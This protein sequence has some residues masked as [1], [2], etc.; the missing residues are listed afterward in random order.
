MRDSTIIQTTSE[1]KEQRR[2]HKLD[3]DMISDT[4]EK[5]FLAGATCEALAKKYKRCPRRIAKLLKSKG[6][7]F[8]KIKFNESFLE[9]DDSF[10][11]WFGGLFAADGNIASDDERKVSISQSHSRGETIISYIKEHLNI[12]VEQKS[13]VVHRFSCFS[14]TLSS[15]LKRK[16]NITPRKSC[17]YVPP[18]I[19]SDDNLRDFMRGYI[20]G[21]GC[22]G[23]YKNK[24]GSEYILCSMVGTAECIG[25]FNDRLKIK[26]CISVINKNSNTVVLSFSGERAVLLLD[27]LYKNENLLKTEKCMTFLNYKGLENPPSWS[28]YNKKMYDNREDIFSHEAAPIVAKRIGVTQQTIYKWR[29][30]GE[31]KIKQIGNLFV[32]DLDVI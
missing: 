22:V 14:E 23:V 13:G 3:W 10:A 32:A 6:L 8:K 11:Y 24:R 18:I 12:D 16:F 27:W 9:E 30:D 15:S 25:Y 2:K 4:I 21:D 5:E 1:P 20:D 28:V 31:F 19:T 7:S 17:T 26:G 29:K